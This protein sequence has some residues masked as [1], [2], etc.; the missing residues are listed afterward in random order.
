MIMTVYCNICTGIRE[1]VSDMKTEHMITCIS[2]DEEIERLKI[3]HQDEL[4]SL[5]MSLQELLNGKL[6]DM[7]SSN[8]IRWQALYN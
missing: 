8:I 4:S 5:N 3:T 2:K 6:S 7:Y 1:Q